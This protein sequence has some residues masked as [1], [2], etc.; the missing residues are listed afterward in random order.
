MSRSSQ[1]RK[2]V[3]AATSG[4]ALGSRMEGGGPV[5]SCKTQRHAEWWQDKRY[6]CRNQHPVQPHGGESQP[7][8]SQ[9]W[10]WSYQHDSMIESLSAAGGD[11]RE[12]ALRLCRRLSQLQAAGIGVQVVSRVMQ[13][14]QRL[15][16]NVCIEV[17]GCC[18]AC[19]DFMVNRVACMLER[20]AH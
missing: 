4:F 11:S 17:W 7:A 13:A 19:E 9:T 14:C 2:H 10:S 5:P 15:G 16:S 3:T 20:Q 1:S 6:N 8:S 12:K 18:S